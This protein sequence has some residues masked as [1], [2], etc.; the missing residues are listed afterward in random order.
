MK[1]YLVALFDKNTYKRLEKIQIELSNKYNLY[2]KLPKL[3]ITLE[4]IEDPNL[5]K[6]QEIISNILKDYKKFQVK[7]KDVIC[8]YPPYKSVN[9]KV[10]EEGPITDLSKFFNKILGDHKFNV[11]DNIKDWDLHVSIANT[12]FSSREWSREEFV[13]ACTLLKSQKCDFWGTIEKIELWSP[14]NDY[15]KMII[16]SY[17]L[18]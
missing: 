2:S 15:D 18:K 14:I 16:H 7:I 1:Y 10:D 4:I 3:H 5:D 8:F 9:L 6:L 17:Q 11:R 13:Q 12:N